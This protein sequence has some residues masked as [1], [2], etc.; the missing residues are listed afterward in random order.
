MDIRMS[1]DTGPFALI[2]QQ[3]ADRDVRIAATWALND[4]AEDIRLDVTQRMQVVFDRPTRWTLNAF[5]V[6]KANPTTLQ[7]EVRQRA[8]SASRHYL[9]VQEEGGP[10]PQ[11]GFEALLSRSLAYEGVVQ[12]IIPAD[13]AR[14][15]AYGNW[16]QGEKNR[17]LSDLQAQRDGTANSTVASR[18]RGRGRARYF[19]P[20]SGLTG[21]AIYKR[22]AGGQIGVVAVISAK[23][24]VYQQR[25]GFF[26][27]AG[28]LFAARMSDHLSRTMTKMIEKRFG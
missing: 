24:P 27:N 26:D 6:G 22:E 21:N 17:V 10:R 20:K 23:V 1:I 25:L 8:G 13:N 9:R 11:T 14:L 12:S 7:A 18:K 4:M 5:E 19:M 2:M 3:M 15:D 28:Q 16:S